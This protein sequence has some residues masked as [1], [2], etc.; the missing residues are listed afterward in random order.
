MFETMDSAFRIKQYQSLVECL[1]R[2]ECVDLISVVLITLTPTGGLVLVN[3]A[4][5]E[6]F[7]DVMEQLHEAES[8][9][10]QS[11]DLPLDMGRPIIAG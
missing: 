9:Q 2:L 5:A 8:G 1:F 10:N 7:D 6:A 4:L 11:I 3:F